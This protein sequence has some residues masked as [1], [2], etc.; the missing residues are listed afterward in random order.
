MNEK[1]TLYLRFFESTCTVL[2]FALSKRDTI[3][4]NI[5]S[6]NGAAF[7][8]ASLIVHADSNSVKY[9]CK[10]LI[11]ENQ[12]SENILGGSLFNVTYNIQEG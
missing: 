2:D 11:E 8:K 1:V 10:K 12:K 6:N 4:S 9:K 3:S 5:L 7:N